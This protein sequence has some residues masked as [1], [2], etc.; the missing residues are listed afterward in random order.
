MAGLA[1]FLERLLTDGEVV[2]EEPP[3]FTP[4]EWRHAMDVLRRAY[5]THALDVAGPQLPFREETALASA[6]LVRRACWFLVD[7][8]DPAEVIEQALDLAPAKAPADHLA[9]DL[10][11]R[12]VPVL[13]GRARALAADDPLAVR[14]SQLMRRWP[15]SGV[16]ADIEDE[17]ITP[18]EFGGHPGLLLLFAERLAEHFKPAWV[19]HGKAF[20][21]VELVFQEAGRP[22]PQPWHTQ[23]EHRHE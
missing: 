10:V 9:A 20:E 6:E 21:Y 22:T 7:H 5:K 1:E 2:F 13:L 23:D 4:V 11:L 8:H 19:P 14:L 17:P 12:F 3:R 16:L 15:L 18:I